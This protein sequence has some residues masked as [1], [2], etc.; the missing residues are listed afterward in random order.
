VS[1]YDRKKDIDNVFR[2][3]VAVRNKKLLGAEIEKRLKQLT[4]EKNPRLDEY[5]LKYYIYL[6]P[7]NRYNVELSKY[8]ADKGN[9]E[10]SRR[11]LQRILKGRSGSE[12]AVLL[13]EQ[14]VAEK[15]YTEAKKILLPVTT[16]V[17]F[18]GQACLLMARILEAE[19]DDNGAAGYRQRAVRVLQAQKDPYRVAEVLMRS[20]NK[21]EALKNYAKAA[22]KGDVTA[23]IKAADLYYAAGKT[24]L[25]RQYYKKAI[26]KGIK[27]PKSLQWA[28]YQYGKLSDDDEYLNKAK[29]GGGMVAETA[30]L[31]KALR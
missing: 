12:A 16:D 3:L 14:Y 31:M 22:D 20:G 24:G 10:V 28:S 23:M 9:K 8:M 26:E 5:L 1:I 11:I 17:H 18:S 2:Y 7:D 25:A 30:E 4:E 27:D 21:N 6:D 29:T 19:G 15:R 13:G